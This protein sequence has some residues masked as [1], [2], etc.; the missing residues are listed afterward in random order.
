MVALALRIGGFPHEG[1]DLP[2]TLAIRQS[3]TD[4]L[5]DRN[6]AGHRTSSR[7]SFDHA[8]GWVREQIGGLTIWL[9]PVRN[10]AG[11]AIEI[12][13]L[14]LFGIP[15]PG[16]MLPRSAST[17]AEDAQARFCFDISARVP[18]LGLLI[19][20]RGWLVPDHGE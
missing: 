4:W 6:F 20:Y 15:C 9:Q 8:R 11:L 16:F 10:K 3:G 5:W 2:V 17:E 12:R 14:C 13:R 1:T 19:R 7:L 18:G